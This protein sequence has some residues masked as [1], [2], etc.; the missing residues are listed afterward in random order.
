MCNTTL[1]EYVE[2]LLAQHPGLSDRQASIQAGL[3]NNAVFRLINNITLHPSPITLEKLANKWG[4]DA[5]Y[6]EMMRLAGY[7]V[8]PVP[9]LKDT[10]EAEALTLFRSLSS[11]AREYALKILRGLSKGN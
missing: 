6:Y 11:E 10:E 5:D 8:P 2:R 7:K 9:N 4:T 3:P 1:S